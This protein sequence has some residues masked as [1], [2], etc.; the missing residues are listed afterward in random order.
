MFQSQ[1]IL[2][3]I[4]KWLDYGT[5]TGA[6]PYLNKASYGTYTKDLQVHN[7]LDVS[8]SCDE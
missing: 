4:Y 6:V 7:R 3:S 8:T 1:N 5:L 2:A